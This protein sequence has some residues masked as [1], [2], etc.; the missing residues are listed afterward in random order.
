MIKHYF[1]MSLRHLWRQRRSTAL[2]ILGL[3]IGLSACWII[4]R[5]VDYE[6]SY[7][8]KI[9][10]SDR[11]FQIVSNFRSPEKDEGGFPGVPLSVAPALTHDFTGL[12]QVVPLYHQYA[13]KLTI[14]VSDDRPL[15]EIEDHDFTAT[16]S[17]YFDL[18]PYKWLV[19]S[20][21]R[22]LDAGD[23]VVL[24]Q[25]R[26]EKY[27]PGLNLEMILGRTI[28]YNDTIHRMVS[29]VVADLEY[30]S[31]FEDKEFVTISQ[32]QW[33]TDAWFNSNS[34]HTVFVK[35]LPGQ[36]VDPVLAF[37]N[38]KNLEFNGERQKEL[39]FESSFAALPLTT[40]HFAPQ[41]ASRTRTVTKNVLYGLSGIAFFLLILACINY[42]NL[43]SAQIPQRAREIGILKTLGS[44]PAKL[45]GGFLVETFTIVALATVLS[46][47]F[48][49]LFLILFPE[50]IPE[51]LENFHKGIGFIWFLIV[52]LSV[53]TLASGLYPAW[54]IIKVQTLSVIKGRGEPTNKGR[55]I[56]V[57]KSLIVFQFIIAQ[58]FI[59]S[60]LIIGQQLGYTMKKDLGFTSDAVVNI[61]MP[62]KSDQGGHTDPLLF[63][64]AMGR[65]PEIAGIAMGHTPLSGNH[66]GSIYSYV[67]NAGKIQLSTPQKYIDEDYLDLFRIDLLTGSGFKPRNPGNEILINQIA[68]KELGFTSPEEAIGKTLQ[69]HVGE[70]FSI[71]GG[72]KDF[73]QKKFQVEM[74]PL[75]LRPSV[76]RNVLQT[77]HVKLPSNRSQWP[78]ALAIMES[79]WKNIYPNAPFKYEFNDEKIQSLYES[80][81]RMAKLIKLATGITILISCM[82]LIGLAMLTSFQRTKEIGIRKVLGASVTSVVALLSKDFIRLVLIAIVIA[83]PIAWYAMNRWLQGFAYKI[84]LQWWM[85]AVAGLAAIVVAMFTVA[86]Q[87]MR[88]AMANPTKALQRE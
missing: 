20:P 15:L 45:I 68:C 85:F 16:H 65:H 76:R 35:V 1:K 48:T 42:I 47:V 63:K 80:E 30:P 64:E 51:G 29:G 25:S 72:V 59:A 86:T 34:D 60:T 88:A 12:E 52:L 57:R 19:G 38:R 6:L 73:H 84:E 55:S 32:A 62:Y 33:I 77:Y 78:D 4:F 61:P 7:D 23:K 3:A 22:A 50:Y 18:I 13:E 28:I 17:S 56:N 2:N 41:Y 82:G 49:R 5:I 70:S 37:L 46:A 14:P 87:S 79:E 24:T 44:S 54:L 43:S 21:G 58:I 27:F 75:V 69:N 26:A 36:T 9:P 74:E 8:Q 39:G 71:I 10:D 31:S 81:W 66:W 67:S 11:I 53:T 83:T 40:K